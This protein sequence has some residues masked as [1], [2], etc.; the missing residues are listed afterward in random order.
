MKE[1]LYGKKR[2]NKACTGCWV[3]CTIY[4]HFS[5]FE[6]FCSQ[7]ES[8]PAPAP[9]T[10]TVGRVCSGGVHRQAVGMVR[11]FAQARPVR[12]CWR[13]RCPTFRTL[14]GEDLGRLTILAA[15]VADGWRWAAGFKPVLDSHLRDSKCHNV[16]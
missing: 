1:N 3:F 11:W 16:D 6:F 5:G 10:Q 8:T 7:T 9:V 13:R 14:A 12:L 15:P 4:K 2:A